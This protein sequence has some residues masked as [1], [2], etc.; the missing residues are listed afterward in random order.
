MKIFNFPLL[1]F[2]P[3]S[4]VGLR[5]KISS[6]LMFHSLEPTT[7]NVKHVNKNQISDT[8]FPH[9]FL[10]KQT[11]KRDTPTLWPRSMY[12]MATSSLVS[13]CLSSLATPKFPAPKSFTTSYLSI[14]TA[15]CFLCSFNK[16][17]TY[18]YNIYIDMQ[19]L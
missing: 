5:L 9:F 11:V 3:E 15:Y 6:K 19:L 17:I 13:L 10:G 18:I 14:F 7:P 4:K 12:F 2:S 16:Y 1:H 8:Y